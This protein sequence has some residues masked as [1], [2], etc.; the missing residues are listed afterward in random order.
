MEALIAFFYQWPRKLFALLTATVIWVFANQSITA[1]KM[2]SSIP[3]RVINLPVDKTIHG[4]SPNGLLS[5]RTS[6]TLG[7][8]K[9]VIEQLEPG[10]LQIVLDVSNQPNVGSFQIT[11][12]NLV[13][14]NPNFNLLKHITSVS[15]PELVIKMGPLLTEKIPLIIHSPTGTAPPGYE[16]LDLWPIT[17]TQTVSGPQDEVLMLKNRGL[18]VSFNLNE[19]TK[20]QLDALQGGL[21]DDVV[22]FYV[23]DQW[24]KVAIPFS[25]QGMEP[26]NDPETKSLH[27]SFLR[28]QLL[29]I[30]AELPI[31]VFYP[32][33]YSS[34][35]NPETYPLAPSPF[36]QSKNHLYTI[37]LPLFA[38]HV[39]KLFLEVVKDHIQLDIMTAPPTEREI[40]EWGVS[41][42]DRSHLEDTFTAFL[43]S[44][45]KI[46]VEDSNGRNKDREQHFRNRFRRYMQQFALHLSPRYRFS[47]ESRLEEGKIRVHVPNSS[48]VLPP[49]S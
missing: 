33:K 9:E 38:S 25:I 48:L 32:L 21:Y 40:L 27:L 7:G 13:S 22:N 43:L 49:E 30:K 10:D 17:L 46:N 3:I 28:Q 36:I 37:N 16:F 45:Y 18:E 29:P 12:K 5:K 44:H 11:K 24:K 1:T 8:T 39:S 14:L 2:I 23:P 41:F 19:I 15:H 31:H 35:I 4:L 47:L 20:E 6:L 34:T 26:M 42:I